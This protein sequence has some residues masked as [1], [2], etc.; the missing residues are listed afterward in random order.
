MFN[1]TNKHHVDDVALLA[2]HRLVQNRKADAPVVNLS[3]PG[4]ADMFQPDN[5]PLAAPLPPPPAAI[6]SPRHCAP[7]PMMKLDQF[8]L[9]YKLSWDI[10]QKLRAIQVTGPH[11]LRLISDVDLCGDGK[12]SIGEV[13]SIRDVQMWWNHTHANPA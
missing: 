9:D 12:L 7:L 13:A 11:V 2:R 4:F 10:K 5:A 1:P 6:N 8:C 3:F